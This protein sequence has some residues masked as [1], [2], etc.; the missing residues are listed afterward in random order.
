M[1]GH[2]FTQ[3]ERAILVKNKHIAKVTDHTVSFTPTFKK[4]A[5]A[6]NV[7]KGRRPQDIFITEGITISI[8]GGDIPQR[9]LG[10]WRKKVK[11]IGVSALGEDNRGR[12]KGSSGRK[13]KE[14]IDESKMS[15][16]EII[17]YYKAR[18]EYTDAENDFLALTRGIPR[19]PPF[20]YRPGS[21]TAS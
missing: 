13:K 18:C 17:E 20:V 21:N 16:K 6:E 11:E 2:K 9:N 7:D 1:K 19:M 3:E 4:F 15:D 10:A 12:N 14:R 5:V 8:I